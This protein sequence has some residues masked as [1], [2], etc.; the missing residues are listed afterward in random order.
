MKKKFN[1]SLFL[2]CLA[3]GLA[4]C[5]IAGAIYV[6]KNQDWNPM[7]LTGMYFAVLSFSIC[8][9]GTVSEWITNHLSGEIWKAY[10]VKS[11]FLVLLGTVGVFF[12]LGALFQFLY[13]LG[14]GWTA[15]VGVDDY[16][17]MIDNSGS[18]GETDPD[19]ERF[20]AIVDFAD[21]LRPEQKIQVSIFNAENYTVFPLNDAL[22]AAK[23]LGGIFDQYESD[24]NTNI[25]G[26]LMDS[27]DEYGG[28]ERKAMAILLSDG[29]GIVNINDIADAYINSD[30]LLFTIGFSNIGVQG[31]DVLSR[32]AESTGGCFYDIGDISQLSS[33]LSKIVRYESRRML[34]DYRSG[35][36]RSKV[37]YMILR[38]LFLTLLGT[39]IGVPLIFMLNSEELILPAMAVRGAASLAAGIV[40]E[41]GLYHFLPP[42]NLRLVMCLFMALTVSF[43]TVKEQMDFVSG[44]G[45]YTG[46]DMSQ[47]QDGLG[48]G[49]RGSRFREGNSALDNERGPRTR[50]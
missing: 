6:R 18:T 40:V 39:A 14:G 34:L 16:I 38:V 42:G 35:R 25:Q 10:E 30:I 23:S 17:I 45:S 1:L 9:F 12:V 33:A 41:A 22:E 29:A 11:A 48:V 3:G 27:L 37:V 20:S 2:A 44:I 26:A 13:G 49:R 28:S 36:D 19:R 8:L 32:I 21:S 24:G 31:R 50:R 46:R 43:Y 47:F 4:G 7:I 5:L 15:D